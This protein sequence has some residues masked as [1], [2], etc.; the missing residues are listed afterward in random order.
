MAPKKMRCTFHVVGQSETACK[1]AAQRMFGDC[2]FCSGHFCAKHRLPEDHRCIGLE[3]VSHPP[4]SPDF[5]TTPWWAVGL[6]AVLSE[7]ERES[8]ANYLSPPVPEGVP[9][10]QCCPA[11]V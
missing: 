11:R 5:A 10:P 9:R 6:D 2:G 1:E 4:A 3:D 8:L 7:S